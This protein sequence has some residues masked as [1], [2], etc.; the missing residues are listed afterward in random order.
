MKQETKLIIGEILLYIEANPILLDKILTRIDISDE[1]YIEA[2]Q[3][4]NKQ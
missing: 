4:F 3:D 2:K 1:V